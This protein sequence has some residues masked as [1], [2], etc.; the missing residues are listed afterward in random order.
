MRARG[1]CSTANLSGIAPKLA[2]KQYGIWRLPPQRSIEWLCATPHV[3]DQDTAAPASKLGLH[4][5]DEALSDPTPS[6]FRRDDQLAQIRPEAKVVSTRK[7]G[8]RAIVLPHER[9]VA[10]ALDG[11]GEGRVGPPGLPKPGLRLHQPAN[12][13]KI[14]ASRLANQILRSP[15]YG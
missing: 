1:V 6:G 10:S 14:L 2:P 15:L 9:Q 13:Q 4:A 12:G 11:P 7:T 8:D 5:L 3:C